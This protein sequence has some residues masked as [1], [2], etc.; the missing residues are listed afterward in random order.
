MLLRDEWQKQKEKSQTFCSSVAVTDV[1]LV[2][3]ALC[4]T[5][6]VPVHHQVD[7]VIFLRLEENKTQP[8]AAC[9]L[10]KGALWNR[11]ISQSCPPTGKNFSSAASPISE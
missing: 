7:R 2:K 11:L 1:L 5:F 6:G 4:L 9:F 10:S 3:A 8:Q